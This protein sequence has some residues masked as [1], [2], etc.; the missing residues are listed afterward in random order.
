MYVS[1]IIRAR[2]LVA[3]WCFLEKSLLCEVTCHR[4]APWSSALMDKQPWDGRSVEAGLL[5]VSFTAVAPVLR[6]A[7]GKFKYLLN[8]YPRDPDWDLKSQ[9]T[10]SSI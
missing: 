7:E 3:S 6:T 5:S 9:V 1:K 10:L 2:F 8:E 4:M